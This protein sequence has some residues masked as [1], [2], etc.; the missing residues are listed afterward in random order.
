MGGGLSRDC[1]EKENFKDV[2]NTDEKLRGLRGC[3]P[4]AANKEAWAL[5][6]EGNS[7]SARNVNEYARAEFNRCSPL[8]RLASG[9]SSAA[10]LA[11]MPSAQ[12]Q[13]SS[14]KVSSMVKRVVEATG[15][16]LEQLLGQQNSTGP[17]PVWATSSHAVRPTSR[18]VAMMNHH[19][20]VRHCHTCV[21][22]AH[23]DSKMTFA[24]Q[25]CPGNLSPLVQRRTAVRD[26]QLP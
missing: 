14:P 12:S 1:T 3:V 15:H 21:G 20:Y 13:P 26:F 22:E 18:C 23:A 19:F 2:K 10:G 16:G 24:L 7:T 9:S 8:P 6:L 5:H 17:A 11:S 4:C 25:M